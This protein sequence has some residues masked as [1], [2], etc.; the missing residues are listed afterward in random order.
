MNTVRVIFFL[1]IAICT[2]NSLPLPESSLEVDDE[3][4]PEYRLG[5][6]YD[7]Y[8]VSNHFILFTKKVSLS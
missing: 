3:D 8:P 2:C 6:R 5:V 1:F 7:E 4:Y